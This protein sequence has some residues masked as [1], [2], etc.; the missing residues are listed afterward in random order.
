MDRGF[1]TIHR[2][3]FDS[4]LAGNPYRLSLWVHLILLA[5]HKDKKFLWN[6]KPV[7]VKR[8]Q[9][10]TGRKKLSI[11]TGISPSYI[12]KILKEFEFEGIKMKL[13]YGFR[14]HILPFSLHLDEHVSIP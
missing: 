9:L 3:L 1:I 2:K 4:Y 11:L 6:G 8:G 13:A 10:I 5:N 12:Q 14:P 7:E